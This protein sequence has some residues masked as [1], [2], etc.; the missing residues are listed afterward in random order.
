MF[1]PN[2][3]TV[4]APNLKLVTMGEMKAML[5]SLLNSQNVVT[6]EGGDT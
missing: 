4:T 1:L 6:N 3:S 2:T 5:H